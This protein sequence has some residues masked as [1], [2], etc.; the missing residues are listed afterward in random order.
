MRG[1][2][3]VKIEVKALCTTTYYT[4]CRRSVSRL[5]DAAILPTVISSTKKLQNQN[6]SE[7]KIGAQSN[8]NR[9]VLET[10]GLWG[11][12]NLFFF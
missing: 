3:R 12:S 2:K 9:R 1:A 7:P 10:G 11:E 4:F 5:G 8:K 6:R